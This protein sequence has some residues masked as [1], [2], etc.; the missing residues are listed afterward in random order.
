MA[1]FLQ[2]IEE[3]EIYPVVVH[4]NYLMN[5]SSPDESL[6]QRSQEV[7][8]DELLRCQ[9]LKA[10]YLVLH[11]GNH[12]GLGT[13][14]GIEQLVKA[15]NRNQGSTPLLLENTAGA[16]TEIGSTFSQLAAIRDQLV[17]PAGICLD[18]CH[19][20]VAGYDLT[21]QRGINRTVKEMESFL[22][23]DGLQLIHVNDS[24]GTLSSR[25]DHHQHIGEGNL[26]AEGFSRLLLHPFLK[27]TPLILET[28]QKNK[29]DREKNISRLYG[30]VSERTAHEGS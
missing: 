7:F 12:R 15:L 3:Y 8:A 26:G 21:T 28:P 10:D 24:R 1:G 19:A 29:G 9:A 6:Y 23:L 27:E 13:A 2:G 14:H 30:L 16:G 18:T 20:Y 17:V 22:G 11:P 4:S 25:R 5:L